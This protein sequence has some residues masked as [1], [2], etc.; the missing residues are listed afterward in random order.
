MTKS[1]PLL[2]PRHLPAVP[3]TTARCLLLKMC[4]WGQG[5]SSALPLL[6][7]M[8]RLHKAGACASPLRGFALL[9]QDFH[10]TVLKNFTKARLTFVCHITAGHSKAQGPWE[11]TVEP[12]EKP[13]CPLPVWT[14]SRLI[15]GLVR[16]RGERCT[17]VL[18]CITLWVLGFLPG[19]YITFV[20]PTPVWPLVPIA[21]P[22]GRGKQLLLNISLDETWP[23]ES[24]VFFIFSGWGKLRTSALFKYILLYQ[25]FK[26]SVFEVSLKMLSL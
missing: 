19:S 21:V 23:L 26:M 15:P 14:F 7:M 6:Q 18:I 4:H 24:W 25:F 12:C 10:S 3:V 22:Q 13:L 5:L 17:L 16:W 20:L 8:G 1:R 9:H 11:K 2:E